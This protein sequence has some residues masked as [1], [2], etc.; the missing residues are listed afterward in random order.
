MAHFAQIDE[1]GTV[2][3]VIVVADE[4]EADG[5]QWCANLL[6]GTWKQTSYSTNA[7]E[8]GLGGTPLRKNY[9][10]IGMKYD[11][12]RDAFIPP[13]PFPSWQL[14]EDTCRWEP[15]IPAPEEPST[16]NEEDQAWEPIEFP[17]GWAPPHEQEPPEPVE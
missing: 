5:E 12:E 13:K 17:E 1:A 11:S 3:Q 7:G 14:N 16:W 4:H 15:P 2:T 9:A 10:G 6:G 8:H